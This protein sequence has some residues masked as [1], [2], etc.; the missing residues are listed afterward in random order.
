MV[1]YSRIDLAKYVVLPVWFGCNNDC[2]ICML[3]GLKKNLPV[4]EFDVYKRIITDIVN[5]GKYENLILSGAEITTFEDLNKY[6][7][8]AASFGWFKQIQIQTNARRLRDKDYL[9]RLIDSGLNEFFISLH[10]F[11]EVHDA[12]TRTSGSF[13][14]AL[15][16]IHNLKGLGV[17]VITNTVLTK[18][19]Y[20][21]LVPLM[22][23]LCEEEISEL[24]LWNFCPME[25]TDTRDLLVSMSDF[26]ELLPEILSTVKASGKALVLKHFPQCISVE[27]PGF[28]DNGVPMLLIHDNFWRKFGENRYGECVHRDI[29]KAKEC[30]GLS[31]A[32]IQ[33]YG[34]ERGLLSPVV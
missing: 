29:C 15:E 16:G 5:D 26:V 33:K 28:F 24:H 14:E 4:I 19:N 27:E 25:R 8:F 1:A 32:H 22:A 34:V 30:C 11:E 6:L 2:T 3:T 17:N 23:K 13:K 21:D 10:G 9:H 12:I 31:S 20:H 7:R 18:T